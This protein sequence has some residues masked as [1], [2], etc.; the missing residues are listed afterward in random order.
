MQGNR[1]QLPA[2]ASEAQAAPVPGLWAEAGPPPSVLG[3]SAARLPGVAGIPQIPG[4]PQTSMLGSELPELPLW[5]SMPGQAMLGG[6]LGQQ[7][8]YSMFP[9]SLN[10][11]LA[12]SM[13]MP[14]LGAPGLGPPG[15]GGFS[16]AG[17]YGQFGT[18]NGG[19]SAVLLAR[20]WADV[21]TVLLFVG[22]GLF[23]KAFLLRCQ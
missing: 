13:G 8:A 10:T 16:Y 3:S 19:E 4:V 14:G 22:C 18:A 7:Q 1:T 6:Q 5:P 17:S 9:G 23:R 15:Q 20:C 2:A 12:L 21:M 11:S